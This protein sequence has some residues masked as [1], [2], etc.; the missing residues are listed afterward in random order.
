M[1]NSQKGFIVPLLLLIITILVVGVAVYVYKKERVKTPASDAGIQKAVTLSLKTYTNEKYGFEFKYPENFS[2]K[3]PPQSSDF[4][5]V[6]DVFYKEAE[7]S[8]LGAA[9][10]MRVLVDDTSKP[11][12]FQEYLKV[13]PLRSANT[14]REY[15]F[16]DFTQRKLG[17]NIFYSILTERFEGTLAF[18]YYTIVDKKVFIF[19]LQSQGVDWT[20]PNLDI[21][22]DKYHTIFRQILSTLKFTK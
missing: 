13:H 21:E 18:D 22:N 16:K 14:N 15:Q 19:M 5:S 20:N 8:A 3:V 9:Q 2:I 4:P 12:S 11:V 1:K 7:T 10:L 17:D 6:V